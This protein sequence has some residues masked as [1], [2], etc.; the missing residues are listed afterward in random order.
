MKILKD[1]AFLFNK[2]A[3]GAAIRLIKCLPSFVTSNKEHLYL[4]N[5]ANNTATLY[6]KDVTYNPQS[7]AIID[8]HD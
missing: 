8:P 1:N 7:L 3:V 6:G 5:F 2:A 4:N